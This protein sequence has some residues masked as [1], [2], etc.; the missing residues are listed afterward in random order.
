MRILPAQTPPGLCLGVDE[1]VDGAIP[2]QRVRPFVA[3][4]LDSL[5]FPHFIAE[6]DHE[7]FFPSRALAQIG[8]G[9]PGSPNDDGKGWRAVPPKAKRYPQGM[10][11]PQGA[12]DNG[13]RMA[14]LVQDAARRLAPNFGGCG[15]Q[16]GNL[17]GSVGKRHTKFPAS[18]PFSSRPGQRIT[19]GP[20]APASA[21]APP[22]H[23]W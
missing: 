22:C 10:D 7:P 16:G 21:P 1:A 8:F 19:S 5:R 4:H 18:G 12:Q 23:H 11:A 14:R 6:E 3:Q 15:Q 20:Q 17:D 9:E 2:C 13:L